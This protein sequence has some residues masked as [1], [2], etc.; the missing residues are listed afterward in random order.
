MRT[1]PT[2]HTSRP[3]IDEYDES[4]AEMTAT[5][6]QLS[7]LL[8]VR[9]ATKDPI[10]PIAEELDVGHTVRIKRAAKLSLTK[11]AHKYLR[12]LLHLIRTK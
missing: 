2:T 1:N 10:A 9:N 6:N 7:S 8:L 12:V 4:I 3:V 11:D 5:A